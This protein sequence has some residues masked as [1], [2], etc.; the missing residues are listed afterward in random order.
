MVESKYVSVKL[1]II[2]FFVVAFFGLPSNV[3]ASCSVQGSCTP[4][5][6]HS[7]V[8]GGIEYC[9]TQDNECLQGAD[10]CE[11]VSSYPCTDFDRPFQCVLDDNLYCCPLSGDQCG[12]AAPT[13]LPNPNPFSNGPFP[14]AY[15]PCEDIDNPEF[16]SMRPYQASPCL[17]ELAELDLYC[18]ND[19][20]TRKE[21]QVGPA[22][23]ETCIIPDPNFPGNIQCFFAIDEEVTVGID[24]TD[25]EL[26]IMGNTQLV[27]NQ[28][29]R[30]NPQPERFEWPRLVNEYYD[31]WLTGATHRAEDYLHFHPGVRPDIMALVDFGG[32]IKKL[33]PKDYMLYHGKY[34]QYD[35]ARNTRHNQIYLCTVGGNQVPCWYDFSIPGY[36]HDQGTP[37]LFDDTTPNV[38][39]LLSGGPG[40]AES[41]WYPFV[42]IE[43]RLGMVFA[44]LDPAYQV[45]PDEGNTVDIQNLTFTPIR[46]SDLLYFAHMREGS[47]LSDHLQSTYMPD[48]FP[49]SQFV[50]WGEGMDPYNTYRCD[51]E[52]VRWNT[53]DDLF[54]ELA[55]RHD[56]PIE[57]P[58]TGEEVS[59]E[60]IEAIISYT[61]TFGCHFQCDGTWVGNE[62]T[63]ATCYITCMNDCFAGGGPPPP[64]LTC[65]QYCLDTCSSEQFC[66]PAPVAMT[67]TQIY[68]RSPL[69][70]ELWDRAVSGPRSMMKRILPKLGVFGM[71]DEYKDYPAVTS[72]DYYTT[73]DGYEILAGDP[74]KERPG[75]EAEIYIPHLGGIKVFAMQTIQDTLRPKIMGSNYLED[76]GGPP[77]GSGGPPQQCSLGVG[78]CAPSE[79]DPPFEEGGSADE[80]SIICQRESGG[81]IEALNDNCL[82]SSDNINNDSDGPN[83]VDLDDTVANGC[84]LPEYDGATADYSVGLFQINLH[85]LATFTPRCQAFGTAFEM[86]YAA[87]GT[88]DKPLQWCNVVSESALTACREHYWDPDVNIAEAYSLSN[89]GTQWCPNWQTN[90]DNCGLCD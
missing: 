19:L 80:A 54:G 13:P 52:D 74:L 49:N 12:G 1:L 72:A 28:V 45:T 79:L 22:D 63:S 67:A 3:S 8:L 84:P 64:Y 66:D 29:N 47:D 82:L 24:L 58:E 14:T 42:R 23:A 55:N 37:D 25:A 5:E 11:A 7:C 6:T 2:A 77:P 31:W 15:V 38:R 71:F 33:F 18:G 10:A 81:N 88:G 41:Q 43:D 16:H 39:R 46:R 87:N 50:G 35:A 20:I 48:E 68:T 59:G 9:C 65:D 57:V 86:D 85:P 70:E 53:G 78:A 30:G 60:N 61:S 26:P 32:P 34:P 75:S 51:L 62:C 73:T 83:C 36:R 44:N 69:T 76:P 40:E 89:G 27:S 56:P 17:E 21:Y 90:G 4:E